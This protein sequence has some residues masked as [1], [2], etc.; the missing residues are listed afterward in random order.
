M[1]LC[2]TVLFFCNFQ[3]K[4]LNKIIFLNCGYFKLKFSEY[5]DYD[6]EMYIS[7][8]IV[9]TGLFTVSLI[10]PSFCRLGFFVFLIVYT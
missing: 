9:T 7:S 10:V 4:I 8:V 2:E 5:D 6:I 1:I 3:Q